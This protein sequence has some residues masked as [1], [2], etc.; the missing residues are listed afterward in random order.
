[1]ALALMLTVQYFMH[2]CSTS[3]LTI[4][5]LILRSFHLNTKFYIQSPKIGLLLF[6]RTIHGW[7]IKIIHPFLIRSIRTPMISSYSG[8]G[9]KRRYKLRY[10]SHAASVA[11]GRSL[12]R[13]CSVTPSGAHLLCACMSHHGEQRVYDQ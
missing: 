11:P 6:Y 8:A 4:P 10:T 12:G 13:H 3:T 9:P 7:L 1:M 2:T 5:L